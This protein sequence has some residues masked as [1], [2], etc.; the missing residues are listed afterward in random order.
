[1]TSWIA[2]AKIIL[3][4]EH[5]VVYGEPAIAVPVASLKAEAT[6]KPSTDGFKII[7]H[8][9]DAVIVR[10]D[11]S[12]IEEPLQRTLALLQ[13]Y[14]GKSLPDV[15]IHLRSSIPMA[16]GLGSGA[17]ISTALLRAVSSAMDADLSDEI[18]N[19]LVFEVEK[20]HHGTPSGIDNTVI[21]YEQPIF[22]VRNQP[23][24][25]LSIARSFKLI[26]GDTG[27]K[28]LTH[29]AVGDVRKLMETDPES[30][31]KRVKAIGKIA[32]AA[33]QAIETGKITDLGVLMH[34][35]HHLLQELTVSSPD[36]DQFVEAALSAGAIGAK[37]SGGGRG[38]NMIAL[39]T[40]DCAEA[41]ANALRQAGAVHVFETTVA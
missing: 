30:T 24:E 1:M 22:Y 11:V 33:R 10:Y 6:V 2:P 15:E 29:V 9:M 8:D 27:Q 35:N 21:V 39:V 40:D 34:K 18:V 31:G 28:A 12:L 37:M 7:A 19:S 16:S 25:R 4:G 26:I 41:V 17:A 3:F 36:L 13:Q 23:I 32:V 20:I 14:T 5:A 38:G